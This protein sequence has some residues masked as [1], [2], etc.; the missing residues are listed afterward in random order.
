MACILGLY[1]ATVCGSIKTCRPKAEDHIIT[2]FTARPDAERI[3]WWVLTAS[4][5]IICRKTVYNLK[6]LFITLRHLIY[7]KNN[8]TR[9]LLMIRFH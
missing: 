1:G 5:C 6:R 9:S 2:I 7:R 4:I 3:Y 8:S